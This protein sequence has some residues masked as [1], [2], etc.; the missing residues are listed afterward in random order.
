MKG[1]CIV[2]FL[3]VSLCVC[4]CEQSEQDRNAT[5]PV[6]EKNEDGFETMIFEEPDDFYTKDA[7]ECIFDDNGE[8]PCYYLLISEGKKM[9][10]KYYLFDLK[11]GWKEEPVPWIDKL[12]LQ[13]GEKLGALFADSSENYYAYISNN[14]RI[15]KLYCYSKNIEKR[16][17][18][19]RK[20]FD[21]YSEL[22]FFTLSITNDDKLVFFFSDNE[23]PEWNDA[24]SKVVLYDPITETVVATNENIDPLLSVFG[25][26]DSV[27]YV[28][29]AQ[30]GVMGKNLKENIASTFISCEGITDDGSSRISIRDDKGYLCSSKGLYGGSF[31]DKEWKQIIPA[32]TYNKVDGRQWK[33]S[34][35]MKVP[36]DDKEFLLNLYEEESGASKWVYCY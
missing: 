15:G 12:E 32:E 34:G 11:E 28:T 36:G 26:D 25:P 24:M 30:K 35:F 5:A 6:I 8:Y 9:R 23:N 1:K 4:A 29:E 19:I 10:I 33:V 13:T 27:Y 22:D 2:V 16:T 17:L 31:D 7:V 21:V 20:V 14:E 18:D 3:I